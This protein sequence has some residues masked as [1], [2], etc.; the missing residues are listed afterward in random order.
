MDAPARRPIKRG[1]FAL[2]Q[3]THAHAR[4]HTHTHTHTH[5]KANRYRFDKKLILFTLINSGAKLMACLG[6]EEASVLATRLIVTYRPGG[7]TQRR[8]P[9]RL[10]HLANRNLL[11]AVAV[12]PLHG[13]AAGLQ[14]P[15]LLP[16]PGLGLFPGPGAAGWLDR[17][18]F[19]HLLRRGPSS[20][21]LQDV[22]AN[23]WWFGMASASGTIS[24]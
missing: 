7:S 11:S 18:V 16:R 9:H 2:T 4:T 5:T 8:E 10:L 21:Y 12:T 15:L 23:S 1:Y 13:A 24:K 20:E 19:R 3:N 17:G 22:A 6:Y 14:K